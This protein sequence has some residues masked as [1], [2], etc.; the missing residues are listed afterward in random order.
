M[1][2]QRQ[3]RSLAIAAEPRDQVGTVGIPGQKLASPAGLLEQRLEVKLGIGFVPGRVDGVEADQTL[4]QLHGL[5]ADAVLAAARSRDCHAATIA[6]LAP[7]A[8]Q[9]FETGDEHERRSDVPFAEAPLAVR[10]R[11]R[12]LD[13]LVGQEHIL[14]P[15]SAL[16]TAIESGQPHSSILYG[17]PGSGKTT[18]ARIAAA[19]RRGGLRGGVGGQRRTGRDPGSDRARS[20]APANDR[21]RRSSSSTRSTASTRPSRTRCCPRSRRAC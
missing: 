15:G 8:E 11:P 6:I 5:G 16:R 7:M 17:P 19:A 14:G 13:E 2:D 18:L 21:G 9:L 3:R 10:M 4:Q 12:G 20:R 1:A